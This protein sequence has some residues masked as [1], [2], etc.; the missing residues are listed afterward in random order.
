MICSGIRHIALGRDVE[1]GILSFP[2]IIFPLTFF[3]TRQ[4]CQSRSIRIIFKHSLIC[5]QQLTSNSIG[6]MPFQSPRHPKNFTNIRLFYGICENAKKTTSWQNGYRMHNFN[7][8]SFQDCQYFQSDEGSLFITEFYA[9]DLD[10]KYSEQDAKVRESESPTFPN[11]WKTEIHRRYDNGC[12]PTEKK[13]ES[14]PDYSRL[15]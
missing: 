8:A 1:C 7:D 14:T 12:K 13:I 15:L 9:E 5:A 11:D 2:V 3:R 4:L 6:I 10:G